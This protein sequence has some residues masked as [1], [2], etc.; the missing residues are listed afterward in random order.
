MKYVIYPEQSITDI[1][2]AIKEKKGV[3][4]TYTVS[5]MPSAIR[6]IPQ[7]VNSYTQE[8]VTVDSALSSSS[9]N[10]VQN[11]VINTAIQTLTTSINNKA[12]KPIV[13]GT[14]NYTAGS[15]ALTTG[16]LVLIYE[17]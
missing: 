13:T 2:N 7:T 14:D 11:K 8:T 15:T 3:N 16:Q 10:P 5:E 1:S 6:S 9:E 17:D 12:T 4:K